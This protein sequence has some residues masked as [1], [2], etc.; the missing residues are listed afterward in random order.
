MTSAGGSPIADAEG[1]STSR[2]AGAWRADVVIPTFN[3]PPWRLD[4]AIESALRA[5]WAQRVIVVDD[6][7]SP[8]AQPAAAGDARIRLER[9]ASN[10]GP[11]AARNRGLDLS[12]T[13][14]VA[15]LDDDDELL[16]GAE[17]SLE[18]AVHLGAAAVVSAREERKPDGQI[19]RRNAPPHWADQALPAPGDVFE[20]VALFGASGVIIGPPALSARLRFDESLRIGEDREFL[21]RA[22][23]LGPIGVCSEIALRVT[24]HDSAGNLTSPAHAARRVRDFVAILARHHDS[25]SD[26]HF[27]AS[28]RWLLSQL[29]KWRSDEATWRLLTNAFR[30]RGW[31]I[32]LKPRLRRLVRRPRAGAASPA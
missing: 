12:T 8:P 31:A 10:A 18:L 30:E 22:A 3:A 20:P 24:L 19:R 9:L 17:R 29:A 13:A 28:A 11:S 2:L 27:R 1:E 6:G 23:D 5:S 32:P 25:H 7:S 4:R 21:R 26:A 14:F 15:L 16:P